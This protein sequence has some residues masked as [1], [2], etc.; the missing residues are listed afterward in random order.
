MA[1]KLGN[2]IERYMLAYSPR[3]ISN[4]LNNILTG[5]DWL[6]SQD[7]QFAEHGFN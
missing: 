1:S 7:A 2:K 6:M 5:P 3:S 4:E